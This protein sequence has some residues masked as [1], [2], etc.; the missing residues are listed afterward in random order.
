MEIDGQNSVNVRGC[1][2]VGRR[3]VPEVVEWTPRSDGFGFQAEHAGYAHLPCRA[4]HR[5]KM[6]WADEELQIE[7]TV[8]VRRVVDAVSRIHFAPSCRVV[9]EDQ[10]AGIEAGRHR[11]FLHFD[12]S[13]TATIE[14]K[15][16][17]PTFGAAR[18]RQVLV[19][20]HR[21]TRSANSWLVRIG[22]SRPEIES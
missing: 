3:V 5:R 12:D 2:R 10:I 16:C 14:T 13:C 6:V 19:M 4:I 22:R 20:N 1:F 8:T 15:L 21:L 9:I 7:D 18:E 11:Y 17:H